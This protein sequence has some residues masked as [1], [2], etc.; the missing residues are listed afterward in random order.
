MII[1]I[2]VGMLVF[3]LVILFITHRQSF[4][5]A[6]EWKEKYWD[7]NRLHLDTRLEL[8]HYTQVAID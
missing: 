8:D 6:N 1:S 4:K 3:W 7:E 5:S 2:I